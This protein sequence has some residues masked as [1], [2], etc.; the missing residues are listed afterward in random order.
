MFAA[1]FLKGR[2]VLST[3][4]EK[5]SLSNKFYS[6]IFYKTIVVTNTNAQA[7]RKYFTLIFLFGFCKNALAMHGKGG[8]ISYQYLG[9][10]S[11][12]NASKYRVTVTHYIDC[13]NEQFT[14]AQVYL[15]IFD[16]GTYSLIKTVTI[17]KTSTVKI[18]KTAY[19]ACINPKPTVCFD[20]VSYIT[21]IEVTNN[22]A[23]YVLSEQECCRVGGIV[24]IQNSS[25]YGITNTNTIPGIVNNVRYR[26]N[27]SP[28]FAQKDT[29]VICHNSFF[30]LDVS[31]TDANGDSLA[32][33]FCP[34]KSGGSMQTRQPNPPSA[35]PYSDLPYGSGFSASSPLGNQ[36]TIDSRKGVV[37]GIAPSATGSYVIAFL[38][39]EYRNG[40][41][42]GANKKELLVTVADCT[43][44]AASL[45]TSYINCDDFTFTFSNEAASSNISSYYWDFGVTNSSTDTSTQPTPAYIYADT[46]TYTLKL[47]V[48]STEGCTDSASSTVKVYPGF[49]PDFSVNGSCYQSPFVFTD[50]TYAKYGA[51]NSWSW[52]FGDVTTTTDTSSLQNPTYQYSI[53]GNVNVTLQVASSKGCSGSLSKTITVNDKPSI[54]LPFTDT[55]ICSNDTLP[56]IVQ[57]AALATYSWNP[58]YNIINAT[59]ANPKVFPQDTTV[60]T[61]TV[62]E[63]GCVGSASVKVNVLDFITVSLNNDTTLC[64]GDTVTLQPISYALSYVWSESN[65][66][67]TLSSST[68]KYPQAF[69][70]STTIYS[71]VANLG[72]CQDSAKTTVYV[73]PYPSAIINND[74]SICF[75]STTQLHASTAAAYFSWSPTNSLL[76]ANTL[77]P[78][79]GPSTTTDYIISI[80]D[81]FYCKKTVNDTIT[82]NV[83]PRVLVNAGNDTS[84]VLNQPLQL[85]ATSNNSTVSYVWSPSTG[86]NNAYIYNPV[87]TITSASTDSIVYKVVTTTPE[88]CYGS[89]DI[90]VKIF[91][92]APEIFVPTAFTPN[93]DGRNDV[94]KPIIAGIQRFDFFKVFDRR[95]QMIFYT[96]A[97][98]N[99][100]D[101]TYKSVA[102]NSGAYVF[103]AQGEYYNG[104]TV[105]R[106]G[107]VVLIR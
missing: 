2:I 30:S 98:D 87:V 4:S 27:S 62:K 56:L 77:N 42:I 100:W 82:V 45:Q 93:G 99:G 28:V 43:L 14:E 49:T 97:A 15:G 7:M 79:A 12:S 59:T 52:S 75:G 8:F 29:A 69:P 71:V 26:D 61:V 11:S 6:L 89:D 67:P 24:N 47:K 34:A 84:V 74:T 60:Y 18:T 16:A 54:Y 55:L 51:I 107:T 40:I 64:K 48:S 17:A 46:G 22:S 36:V 23:G 9:S 92:T 101:G 78:L 10:G 68:L 50:L 91:K 5:A 37:S 86:M 3:L 76:N 88:G 96:S 31:A 33:V 105:F 39:Y 83:I 85:M 53:A 102:Q 38:V 80:S 95:G 32:Y 94:L 66:Y 1:N 63:K 72:H 81:T 13:N 35:P 104:K 25:Q 106:K 70:S 73:S 41:V 19:D 103:I 21:E 58:G 90:T 57:S 20:I 65:E 44:S